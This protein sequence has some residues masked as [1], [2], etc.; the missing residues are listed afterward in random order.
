MLKGIVFISSLLTYWL[1]LL[2]VHIAEV[3]TRMRWVAIRRIV[4]RVHLKEFVNEK[5]RVLRHTPLTVDQAN[6]LKSAILILQSPS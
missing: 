3:K 2:L 5:N 4:Q 1:S 6:I